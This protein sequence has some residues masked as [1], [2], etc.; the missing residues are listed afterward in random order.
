MLK[1]LLM[2]SPRVCGDV[3]NSPSDFLQALKF[4]P[5]MRGCFCEAREESFH[6]KSSPRV[7]GDVSN[8]KCS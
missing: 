8:W 7:C 3:S 6:E 1:A 5:R 2:S 4:S